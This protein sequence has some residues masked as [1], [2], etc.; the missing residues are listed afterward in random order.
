MNQTLTIKGRTYTLT[1]QWNDQKN[2]QEHS[3]Y[4]SNGKHMVT[5]TTRD[6]LSIFGLTDD[7]MRSIV[8]N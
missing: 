6:C 1:T 7:E 8:N 5:G 4:N 2:D 3:I